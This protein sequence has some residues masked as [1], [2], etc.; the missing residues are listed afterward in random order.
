MDIAVGGETLTKKPNVLEELAYRDTWGKGQDS[1]IAMIFERISL[2][3]D[4]LAIDGTIYIHCD[5]RVSPF[6]RLVLDE[7]F[8]KFIAEISWKKLRSP[9]SQS[10]H[11]SNIKDS[12]FIYSKTNNP[13][14]NAQFVPKDKK[15]LET[16]YRHEDPDTG[17]RYNLD[18]FTQKGPGP[19]RNFNGKILD[20]PPGKH[21]IWSQKRI[22]EGMKNGS[23]V[24]S[25]GG[26]PYVKRYFDDNEG[27]RVGDIWD[28]INP[29]NQMSKERVD[30]PTQNQK[31]YWNALLKH[32]PIKVILWRISF[33]VLVQHS[34]LRKSL[35]GSGLAQI[36]E[37][38]L[39]TQLEN[40]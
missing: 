27:T 11:F 38:F 1:F 7:L 9:K 4:L 18:N 19:A 35:A 3:H 24:F 16:H 36:L 20:P 39:F 2:M 5:W 17:R 32:L 10:A 15:L 12:I 26:I 30:Y 37:N 14:F 8:G 23:I 6:I 29:V 21:W 34:Q 40:V 13:L 33:A 25:K 28:D 31:L 22:D